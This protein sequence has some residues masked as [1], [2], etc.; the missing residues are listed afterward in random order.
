M[1]ERQE[2][3]NGDCYERTPEEVRHERGSF[4]LEKAGTQELIQRFIPP[5][6][7]TMLDV[8]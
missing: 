4:V 1:R 7:A 2:L 6:P 8:G 3:S 5:A